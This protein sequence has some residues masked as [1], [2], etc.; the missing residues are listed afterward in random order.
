MD[1]SVIV[2]EVSC[3]L[4]TE[5]RDKQQ[6]QQQQNTQRSCTRLVHLKKRHISRSMREKS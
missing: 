1:S 4:T 6:Q 5:K 2:V 3:K